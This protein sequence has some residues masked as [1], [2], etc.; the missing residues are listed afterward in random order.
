MNLPNALQ[1]LHEELAIPS[2]YA[3]VCGLPIVEEPAELASIGFDIEGRERF[4][5]ADSA[6]KWRALCA[7]A[8]AQNLCLQVVSAYR[9][10]DY[11][12]DLFRNK[13]RRGLRI[14]DVL[15]VNAAPGFSEHHSGRAL[16]LTTPG[17]EALSQ[18]FETSP[19][20]AWLTEHA[21]DFGFVMSYPRDNPWGIDYEPWHWC[22]RADSAG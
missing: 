17:Y 8:A 11:Q 10:I 14:E 5:A 21:K 15:C 16:D 19:A 3:S 1:V 13:L 20:F 18:G 2:D 6:P 9:S 7:A 4:L 22:A 12:A